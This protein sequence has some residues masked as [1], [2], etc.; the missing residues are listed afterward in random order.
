MTYTV[1]CSVSGCPEVAVHG[2]RCAEHS[3]GAPPLDPTSIGFAA[4][5]AM[6]ELPVVAERVEWFALVVATVDADG[7][8]FTNVYAGPEE[9]PDTRGYQQL[10]ANLKRVARDI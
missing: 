4:A 6:D 1:V 10:A 7:D 8:R 3:T 2:G 5:R 9:R